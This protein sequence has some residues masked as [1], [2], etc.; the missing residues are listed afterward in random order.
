MNVN[1]ICY[2]DHFWSVFYEFLTYFFILTMSS[3]KKLSAGIIKELWE[4]LKRA[5][6][7]LPPCQD[8]GFQFLCFVDG[9][10]NLF[11]LKFTGISKLRGDGIG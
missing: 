8:N 5:H 10:V 3:S 7:P 4:H 1:F 11:C 6:S 2:F 9:S